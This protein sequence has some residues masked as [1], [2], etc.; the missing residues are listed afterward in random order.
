MIQSRFLHGLSAQGLQAV[1][2]A[3]TTRRFKANVVVT[4]QG[5]PATELFLIT[6]GRTRHFFTTPDGHKRLLLW[7]G[8]GEVV[9]AAT[10]LPERSSYRVGTET[11]KETT[12]LAWSRVAIRALAHDNPRL[13]ENALLIGADYVDWFV[14]AHTAL[15]S[16]T[17]RER[18]AG[19]L[20]S[21]APLLGRDVPEGVEL[22][23]TND[24]LANAANITLYTASR[25][26][27]EWQRGQAVIKRRRR[28]ILISPRQLFKHTA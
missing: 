27:N 5:E 4:R 17:A 8:P 14:A 23:I 16:Q 9:G 2:S 1:L 19:V 11:V 12:V 6:S 3:A 28:V 10:L 20:V 15:T 24:E 26:L 21:L 13:F 7:L 22:D 18:L 25:L